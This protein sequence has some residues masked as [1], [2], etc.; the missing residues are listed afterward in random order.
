VIYVMGRVVN[1]E[2]QPVKGARIEL[3]Q[4][5]T[6]GRYIHRATRI[7]RPWIPNFEGFA[8]QTTDSRGRYRFKTIKPGA[9]PRIP[10]GCGHLIFTRRHG[11]SSTAWSRRCISRRKPLNDKDIL[12]QN[13]RANKEGLIARCCRRHRRATGL[14]HRGVGHRLDKG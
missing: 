8:A 2:G 4:A 9:Y 1:L 5:T 6:H 3:W 14:A 13:I 10:P 12:L 7:P 11:A